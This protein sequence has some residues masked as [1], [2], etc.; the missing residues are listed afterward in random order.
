MMN[1]LISEISHYKFIVYTSIYLFIRLSICPSTYIFHLFVHPSAL[2]STIHLSIY[3]SVNPL[4]Y[5]L[6]CPS[7]RQSYTL[8]NSP[9]AIYNEKQLYKCTTKRQY[10]THKGTGKRMRQPALVWDFTRYL[11]GLNR[12]FSRL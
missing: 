12:W 10:P 5:L 6:V 1:V 8:N 4:V 3:L 7:I 11:I 2:S 9:Q